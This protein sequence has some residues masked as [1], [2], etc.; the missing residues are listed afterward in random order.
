MTGFSE[1][2]HG[3]FCL[4]DEHCDTGD[5]NGDGFAD[6]VTFTPDGR[7]FVAL[8]EGAGFGDLSVLGYQKISNLEG[9]F[10][11][12]LA[13]NSLFGTSLAFQPIPDAPRSGV[14][15]V[16]ANQAANFAASNDARIFPLYLGQDGKVDAEYEIGY[17]DLGLTTSDTPGAGL[18]AIGDLDGDEVPD[19]LVG[20]SRDGLTNVGSLFVLFM[21]DSDHDGLDDELDNCISAHNPLQTDD[22]LDGVGNLCDNCPAIANASQADADSDGEGDVCEPVE[23]RLE[24]V[25]PPLPMTPQDAPE[26]SLELEC[27]AFEV[28]AVNAAIVLPAGA[29]NPKTLTL[30]TPTQTTSG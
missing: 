24:L 17:A 7:V 19:L 6:I 10:S 30:T 3:C 22:D 15:Y 4:D 18:D 27:G 1:P 16:G 21:Q 26:W 28:T 11:G 5:F 20:D 13:A 8:W 12:G 29:T 2:V 25:I 9:D 23:L 14:L